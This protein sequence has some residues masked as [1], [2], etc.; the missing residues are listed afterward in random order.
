MASYRHLGE[1]RFTHHEIFRT[2]LLNNMTSVSRS[3]TKLQLPMMYQNGQ[4]ILSNRCHFWWP[5]GKEMLSS[6]RRQ[7]TKRPARQPWR[8][9]R[10]PRTEGQRKAWACFRIA[11]FNPHARE[12]LSR[13][14]ASQSALG[15]LRQFAGVICGEKEVP[16]HTIAH[17]ARQTGLRVPRERG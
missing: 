8:A 15:A 12:E 3:C 17:A 4:V 16:R 11:R 6:A 2:D 10:R 13:F 5:Y 1:E 7:G 9:R 14:S